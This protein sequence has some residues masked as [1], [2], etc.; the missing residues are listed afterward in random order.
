MM[1][2]WLRRKDAVLDEQLRTYLFT[3]GRS[4]RSRRRPRTAAAT[5]ARGARRR[6]PRHRQ[7]ARGG[8]SE[9]PPPR[10]RA[11]QRRGLGRDRG[12]GPPLAAQLPHRP[13]GRRLQRP[14]RWDHPLGPGRVEPRARPRRGRPAP[15]PP[16]AAL[17][18]AAH[19][20]HAGPG[21]ARRGRPGRPRRRSGIRGRRRPPRGPRRGQA[22]LPRRRRRRASAGIVADLAHE[23]VPIS[24]YDEYPRFVAQAVDTLA[25]PASTGPTH[26][27]RARAAT[28]A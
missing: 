26:R 11:H 28:P 25:A 14:A 2:E 8:L 12:R 18:R 5:G 20:L 17:R 1:L 27:A 24:E 6:L 3:A 21:R 16:G 22:G 9:P 23:P 19:G 7:P 4:S 13:Q 15:H 10:A